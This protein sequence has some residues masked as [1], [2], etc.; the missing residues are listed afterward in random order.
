MLSCILAFAFIAS[1]GVSAAAF[2]LGDADVAAQGDSATSASEVGVIVVYADGITDATRDAATDAVDADAVSLLGDERFGLIEAA[3]GATAEETAATLRQQPGILAAVPDLR[4]FL[5]AEPNDPLFDNQWGMRNTGQSVEGQPGGT[6]GADIDVVDAW[7][8]TTGDSSVVVASIDSGYDFGHPDLA[9][10]AWRNTD[11]VAG[12][13]IDDDLN[14]YV[15]DVRGW[16]AYDHDA[17]PTDPGWTAAF[18]PLVPMDLGHG[19]HT[20]GTIGASG[21]DGYGVTGVA[22]HVS[23]MPIRACDS[24]AAA[25]CALSAIIEGI[26]YA[27]ANGARVVNLSVTGDLAAAQAPSALPLALALAAHPELL[28][29][30]AAG[31]SALDADSADPSDPVPYPCAIDPSR[32]DPVIGYVAAPGA[33]DNV[34]CVAAS[35]QADAPAGFTTI[36]ATSVD[37]AAPGVSILSTGFRT[38]TVYP[39]ASDAGDFAG[40]T[41]P[42][43]PASDA[44]QGFATWSG[45]PGLLSDRPPSEGPPLHTPG[46]IRATQSPAVAVGA[47]FRSCFA[48]LRYGASFEPDS[49]LEWSVLLDGEVVHDAS[50]ELVPLNLRTAVSDTIRI[51]DDGAVHDLAVQVRF[52]RG[53]QAPATTFIAVRILSVVIDCRESVHRFSS[54]TSMASPAVAGAAALL[55]SLEPSSTTTELRD[56]ILAGVDVL[57]GLVGAT[58][59]GGRLDVWDALEALSPLDTRILGLTDHG[60]GSVRVT[61]DGA[62]TTG[63]TF[64]CSLDGA[65]FGA[66]TSP[67]ALDDLPTGPHA[68]LVRTVLPGGVDATPASIAWS[69][70]DAHT[71]PASGRLPATGGE[72]PVGGFALLA[73]LLALGALLRARARVPRTAARCRG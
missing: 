30:V 37:L 39:P 28:F 63:A 66:C 47:E 44:S 54:G 49:V 8:R 6:P 14:G 22:Q 56:A 36:G 55:L 41:T 18:G 34:I 73:A 16:D 58:V 50:A 19:I 71:L 46:T 61:F 24:M 64:E 11:E 5:Q 67:I 32:S 51:P 2:D 35:D 72:L 9:P 15:D 59:S 4:L 53:T 48:W 13:G 70:P 26:H 52:A 42:M 3:P 23:I 65:A 68:L 21:D 60:E 7:D 45:V 12:N 17:D 29:V 40:W 38:S 10:I 62:A 20:A 57:P 33:I 43:P 31:N 27:A 69:T 1:G 25:G